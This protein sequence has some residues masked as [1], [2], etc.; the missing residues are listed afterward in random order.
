MER[1]RLSTAAQRSPNTSMP[2]PNR[3]ILVI[4]CIAWCLTF[5]AFAEDLP[6]TEA[7][8]AAA[9]S[10]E[11]ELFYD[12]NLGLFR[13]G[14][15]E[16]KLTTTAAT[17]KLEGVLD[18]KGALGNL[19]KLHGEFTAEGT[20]ENQLPVTQAFEIIEENKK[21]EER[22]VVRVMDNRT[23]I[24]RT[25]KDDWE[26]DTPK[27]N[28]FMTTLFAYS[29]CQDEMRV[30]DEDESFIVRLKEQIEDRKVSQGRKFFS[31]LTTLCQYEFIY[32]DDETR[33][34]DIWYG[35]FQGRI[36]PIRLQIRIAVLPDG[37]FRLRKT[38]RR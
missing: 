36:V 23:T 34:V 16:L 17:Y 26:F 21:K 6:P 38:P 30:F 20:L 9:E 2:M 28:D 27:G 37:I 35:E 33:R 1:L 24:E 25:G 31:G 18:T 4:G 7:P 22:K 8:P 12:V 11:I 15:T 29:S 13:V 5:T 14:E 19:L 10:H 3:S 32:E